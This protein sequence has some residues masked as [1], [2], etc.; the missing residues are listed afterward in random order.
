MMSTKSL[1]KEL[2]EHYQEILLEEKRQTQKIIDGLIITLEQGRKE[3][4]GDLS[5]YSVHQADLGTDTYTMENN[6]FILEKEQK[7]M[8]QINAALK[9]IYEGTYGICPI[10]GKQISLQ[11]LD[12]IPWAL[13]SAEAKLD[14]EKK[15][16]NV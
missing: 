16:S 6:V 1:S 15:H 4:T 9:R 3:Q 13:Y 14:E 12:A 7:K 8:A 2:V 5:S 11:R 10:T